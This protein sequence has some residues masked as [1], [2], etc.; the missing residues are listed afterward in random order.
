[1]RYKRFFENYADK[2]TAIT[3]ADSKSGFQWLKN[4]SDHSV[5]NVVLCL[6]FFHQLK[7]DKEKKKFSRK[8]KK[9]KKKEGHM[10]EKHRGAVFWN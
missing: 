10:V 4:Q 9:K 7:K 2:I 1:M 8:K 6:I 5:E 3:D